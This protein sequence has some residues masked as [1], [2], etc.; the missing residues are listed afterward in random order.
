MCRALVIGACVTLSGYLLYLNPSRKWD[1][2]PALSGGLE[3]HLE[4]AYPV[5]FINEHVPAD[6]KVMMVHINLGFFCEREYLCD[7]FPEAP[8]IVEAIAKAGTVKRL[9]TWLKR[10]NVSHVLVARSHHS[11]FGRETPAYFAEALAKGDGFLRVF[12]DQHF[13]I[14]RVLPD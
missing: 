1:F 12:D 8:Q 5:R 2:R 7:S 3:D 9:K 13:D 14:Y 6:T 4:L 10:E 11:V